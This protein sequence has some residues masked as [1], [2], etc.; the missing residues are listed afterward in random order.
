MFEN[1]N[2]TK[3]PDDIFAEVDKVP[4]TETPGAAPTVPAPAGVRPS[5]MP[6]LNPEPKS[7]P[8]KA[9]KKVLIL[10]LIMAI[11]GGA[12]Y[13]AYEFLLSKK[14]PVDVNEPA[15]QV[16]TIEPVVEEP[17]VDSNPEDLVDPSSDIVDAPMPI[18]L[19]YDKD[20]LSDDE[21]RILG[22]DPLNVDTDKDGLSD[23]EEIKVY[24][25][26]PLLADT[27]G[28]SYNDGQEVSGGYNPNGAG[29]L[30]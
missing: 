6:N 8:T 27:D 9:L 21:E 18:V 14:A 29:K 30:Q 28:D 2:S 3:N 13:A 23:Y 12:A 10:I 25:T 24:N 16:N 26:N 15:P 4:T 5:T 20:G 11:L 22:T 7:S 1:L 19:D 17:I